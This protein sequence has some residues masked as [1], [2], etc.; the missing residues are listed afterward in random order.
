[1]VDDKALE[2][3]FRGRLS[4]LMNVW[5]TPKYISIFIAKRIPALKLAV[6]LA[7]SLLNF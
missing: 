2:A 4:V 3:L 7:K 5:V 6:L 1:V